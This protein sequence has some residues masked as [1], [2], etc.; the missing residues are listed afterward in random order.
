MEQR[1]STEVERLQAFRMGSPEAFEALFGLHQRAVYH[2]TLRLVRQPAAAE[3]LTAETFLRIWQ[4][5]ARFD[6][7]YGFEGWARRISTRAALDWLRRQRPE[8]TL[9]F[10]LASPAV[11]D[12]ALAAEQ[13][14]AV[15]QA[16]ARLSP[17]LR[18]AATL[19]V[20][21]Q[22]PQREVAQALGI[23]LAATKLR[24]FRALRQLRHELQRKGIAP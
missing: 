17:P 13:R 6:P 2:W 16:F 8:Q 3:E 24:I 18:L 4:A 12:P 20:V 10:E 5:H 15:A 1:D 19:A 9:D 14:R 23:S 7:A 22:L 11:A 21:E